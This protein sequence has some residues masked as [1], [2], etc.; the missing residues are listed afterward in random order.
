MLD[1]H[2][3]RRALAS[4]P[5]TD[6]APTDATAGVAMVLAGDPSDLRLCFILRATRKSDRWSGQMAFPGGRAEPSDP[7]TLF[8]AVRETQEEVGVH[9]HNAE[10]LGALPP[11][12]LRPSGALGHLAP[13]VFYAG[14]Q[15]PTLYPSADEVAAA[16][17]IPLSH[18]WD[19]NNCGR[20]NWEW[21]GQTMQFPG[22]QFGEHVIWGLTYRVL[23]QWGTALGRPLPQGDRIPRV[24][25]SPSKSG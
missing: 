20:I 6:E 21:K 10:V 1:L 18:L 23:T 25:G 4:T 11:Q 9:L 7:T 13:F 16:Y 22:I 14:R 12:P 24:G 15:P 3:I 5:A 19:E 8:V 2:A 17:W